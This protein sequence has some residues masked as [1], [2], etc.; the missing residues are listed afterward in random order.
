MSR[1]MAV[2]IGN[3]SIAVGIF[4]GTEL[5]FTG[6]IG[7]MR[8]YTEKELIKALSGLLKNYIHEKSFEKCHNTFVDYPFEGSILSSVV[9]EINVV[10]LRAMEEITGKKPLM[11]SSLLH[12]QIDVSKYDEGRIGAD[13][14]VDLSAAKALFPDRPVMVCDLGTCTTITVADENGQLAGGMISPGIQLCLDAEAQRTAQ[15]PQLSAGE[16]TEILGTDTVSNMMSG[17]VA[18][19]AMMI[20]GV[21]KRVASKYH[22]DEMELVITG[23]LGEYV[24]P[25]ME[26]D[27]Y[28]EKQLLLKGLNAIYWLNSNCDEMGVK[29]ATR[30][31]YTIRS[32]RR[33]R[34]LQVG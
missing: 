15:L 21:A 14:I 2:D 12:T 30:E 25:W 11:M 20:Q 34:S 27:V 23:G 3:S 10:T 16:V 19:T 8:D 22:F 29:Y 6:K 17:A 24:I 7:T 9:P 31:K 13:R 32:Y 4:N 1:I 26:M 18:G 28:Y 33:D 5:E